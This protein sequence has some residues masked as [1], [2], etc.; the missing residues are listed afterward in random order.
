MAKR[1]LALWGVLILL[2]SL[3]VTGFVSAANYLQQQDW[4]QAQPWIDQA[5][6][7][8]AGQLGCPVEDI[9]VQSVEAVEFAD[10]SLGVPEPGRYYLPVITP[11]YVIKLVA[12]GTVYEYH[13]GANQVILSE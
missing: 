1:D 6:A 12:A 8:L 11:G 5:R 10:S 3:L 9:R 7:D 4:A 13:A 2:S